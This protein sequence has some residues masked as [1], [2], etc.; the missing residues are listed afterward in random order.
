LGGLSEVAPALVTTEA[1]NLLKRI[2]R[3][4]AGLQVARI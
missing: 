2:A 4:S 3:E 1:V